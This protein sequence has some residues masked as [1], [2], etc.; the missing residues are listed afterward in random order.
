MEL[1]ATAVFERGG[2]LS[3][4][5]LA[6]YA[7]GEGEIGKAN[8]KSGAGPSSGAYG[9][10]EPTVLAPERLSAFESNVTTDS[11]TTEVIVISSDDEDEIV[12]RRGRRRRV[13]CST[14]SSVTSVVGGAG[15][16][17]CFKVNLIVAGD[18]IARRKG[19]FM[20]LGQLPESR[21]GSYLTWFGMLSM[22]MGFSNECHIANSSWEHILSKG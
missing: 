3:R 4:R 2:G 22:K 18:G 19:N 10:H 17:L 21:L 15:S 14:L 9:R 1:A 13:E 7:Y 16:S 11:S 6:K 20:R 8:V 5:M 12:L